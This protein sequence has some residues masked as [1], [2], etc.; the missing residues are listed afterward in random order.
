MILILHSPFSIL[1]FVRAQ[2]VGPDQQFYLVHDYADDWQVY[3]EG[4]KTYVPYIQERHARYSSFSLFL[5]LETARHYRLLCFSEGEGYLFFDASLQRQIRAGTW[6][7]LNVDS[8]YQ[9]YRKPELLLTFYSRQMGTGAATP[10][11]KKVLLGYQRVANQRSVAVAG[12]LLLAKPRPATD[13]FGNF[14]VLGGLLLLLSFA[15]LFLAY[16]K[17]FTRIFSPRDL[18]TINPRDPTLSINTSLDASNLFFVL[19]LSLSLAFLYMIVANKNLDLFA[20]QLLL[21]EGQT[22]GNLFLNFLEVVLLMFALFMGKYLVL[23]V[24]GGLYRFERLVD[25]HFFKIIQASSLFFSGLLLISMVTE[26]S[27]P[28]FSQQADEYLFVPVVF[29]Y[30]LRLG[31]LYFSINKLASVKN[32]YLFSYLCIVELIPIIVGIRFAL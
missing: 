16:H 31:L 11:D 27:F 12:D 7:V 28:R 23:K 1:H 24:L 26:V 3:D 14:F 13:A 17:A 21:R 20:S 5:N 30:L 19:H 15:F 6:V 10:T 8:L 25:Y 2:G 4:V 29:F 22:L 9:R 32:L 18:L